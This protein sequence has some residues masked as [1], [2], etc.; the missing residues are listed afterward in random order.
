[1]AALKN[2]QHEAFCLAWAGAANFCG[3]DAVDAAGYKVRTPGARRVQASRLLSRPDVQLRVAELLQ[4]RRERADLDADEVIARLRRVADSDPVELYDQD[5]TLRSLEDIPPEVRKAIVAIDVVELRSGGGFVR[6][7]KLADRLRALELLG[8]HLG[9]WNDKLHLE[10]TETKAREMINTA[11]RV[12]VRH[13]KDPN[14]LAA[15][16]A[17]LAEVMGGGDA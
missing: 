1:M 14:V 12:V 15:I 9:L 17:D 5:G 3:G 4:Q 8:R 7:V 10:L 11:V 13:V 6:K 2:A 16:R